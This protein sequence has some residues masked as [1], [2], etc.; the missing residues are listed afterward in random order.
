MKKLIALT[1]LLCT[2]ALMFSSCSNYV[3]IEKPTDANFEYW[4]LDS[5]NKKSFTYIDGIGYLSNNYE[6]IINEDGSLCAP[7]EYVS[8]WFENY[9]FWEVGIDKIM[10]INITDPNVS[11]WGLT[12]NSTKEE[13]VDT[14]SRMGFDI[15]G[16]GKS[17]CF[18][19]YGN[20]EIIFYYNERIRID[21]DVISIVNT[22]YFGQIA[23]N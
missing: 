15:D 9:P 4:L 7:Q 2:L 5:P 12:I 23:Y 1:L 22:I 8:Y 13:F 18:A 17:R 11:V 3:T 14:F 16:P 6:P 19:R 10:C 20:I 21:Y